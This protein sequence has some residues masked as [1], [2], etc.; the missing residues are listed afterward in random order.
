[1]PK[2]TEDQLAVWKQLQ[3]ATALIM[4]RFRTDLAESGLSLEEFDV[5]I[6]LAWAPSG[7][8]PLQDLTASMVVAN[9]LSR[10]G[11]TRLL[12]RMER[13]TLVRRTLSERDR[14][15]FDVTLTPKGRRRFDKVWPEHADG[16]GRY[17]V[18]PLP[19][20]D[21]DELGRILASLIDANE[22]DLG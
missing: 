11:L 10:S 13:D 6:H 2:P 19:Q 14:R 22:S 9:A 5:M 15:R 17:F 20:R 16:I 3:W 7:T 8:L 12:D 4:A 1:M 18:D 21:I